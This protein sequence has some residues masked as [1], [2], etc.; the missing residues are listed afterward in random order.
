MSVAIC[1]EL[2]TTV[3][4]ASTSSAAIREAKLLETDINEPLTPTAVKLLISVALAPTEPL[5][6]VAI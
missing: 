6:S 1:A 2:L 3:P 4:S 5:I